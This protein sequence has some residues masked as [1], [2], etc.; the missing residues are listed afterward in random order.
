MIARV[1]RRLAGALLPLAL[2][3]GPLVVSAAEEHA[4]HGAHASHAINWWHMSMETPPLG[5]FLIDFVIFVALLVHFT[6]KPFARAFASR[7][8]TIARAIAENEAAFGG[9]KAEYDQA[10]DKL[11]A[12]ERE[13]AA[14]ISKV[15]EDGVFE[16]DRIVESARSYA[17]RMREDVKG[18]IA[19]EATAAR[20]RLQKRVAAAALAA[21]E[22]ALVQSI[23]AAD[24]TR[25]IE[26]AIADI[27]K[28]AGGA[29]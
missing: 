28:S 21:A 25:M 2:T 8:D 9:A 13:V 19:N 3:L 23:T 14:L 26:D 27:E 17:S 29:R 1:A 12:V 11:A 18:I 15:K 5:W 4:E 10:R 7:H 20:G 22:Q 16:R 6:R 24:R